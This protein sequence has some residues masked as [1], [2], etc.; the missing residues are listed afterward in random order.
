METHNTDTALTSNPRTQVGSPR[1]MQ[2]GQE[3]WLGFGLYLNSEWE[4]V[5]AGGF[6]T[7]AEVFGPPY[8]GSS[9][10]RLGIHGSNISLNRNFMYGSDRPWLMS[11][12][13]E[14]WLDFAFRF[15]LSTDPAV[16]FYE[17]YLNTGAGWQQ[18]LLG[19]Q[20]RLYFATVDTTNNGGANSSHLK[21]YREANMWPDVKTCYFAGHRI[22]ASLASVD[23]RSYT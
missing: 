14:Q 2:V 15:K 1:V 19:G 3:Y 21:N 10:L 11:L 5:P 4:P 6:V 13:K 7:F 12:I 23:P 18:Q 16:G 17:I 9:P 20:Q 22:G 8:G